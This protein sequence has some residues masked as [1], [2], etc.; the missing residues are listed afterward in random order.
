MPL[1]TQILAATALSAVLSIGASAQELSQS[2]ASELV[3]KYES[4]GGRNIPNF[5]FDRTHTAGGRFQITDTNWRHYAPMVDID[6][7]KW[8]NAMSAPE[9]LQGQVFGIMWAKEGATPWTCCNEKLKSI[10]D[11]E[12]PRSGQR[13]VGASRNTKGVINGQQAIATKPP[14]VKSDT[15][16]S[17][18][19]DVFAKNCVTSRN[20]DVFA[21]N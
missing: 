19:W 16:P 11:T 9:H 6:I 21:K 10:L 5:R 1:P 18:C 12:S 20:W 8:P 15:K 2:S 3:M 14:E 17:H 13:V 4:E 7:D